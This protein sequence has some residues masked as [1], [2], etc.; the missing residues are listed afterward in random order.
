MTG[1]PWP[2]NELTDVAMCDKVLSRADGR[3]VSIAGMPIYSSSKFKWTETKTMTY[4]ENED[5]GEPSGPQQLSGPSPA[6]LQA[7]RNTE[8]LHPCHLESQTET[9]ETGAAGPS[10]RLT[11]E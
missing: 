6:M 9:A 11:L 7:L 2:Q 8:Q 4:T 1:E 3:Q 10:T 5:T